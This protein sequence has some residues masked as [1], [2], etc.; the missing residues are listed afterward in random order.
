MQLWSPQDAQA[1]RFYEATG[2]RH[3]GRT[4]WLAELG[5]VIVAYVKAL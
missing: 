5:L 3:D 1:R 2:W 4:Q